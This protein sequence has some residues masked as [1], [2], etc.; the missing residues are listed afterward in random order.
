MSEYALITHEQLGALCARVKA[1]EE[2]NAAKPEFAELFFDENDIHPN[3]G[4]GS[5]PDAQ[6]ASFAS[7]TTQGGWSVA[8][9]VAS[10]TGT[11]GVV[12]GN[13]S[14]RALDTGPSNYW[15]KPI[16][17]VTETVSG[18]EFYLEE[19]AMQTTGAYDGSVYFDGSF[20]HLNPP[21]NPSY[22]VEYYNIENR[23][24]TL[25]PQADSS[26]V[27]EADCIIQNT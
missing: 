10:Y 22:V 9:N 23:T 15:A 6:P 14:L 18:R 12:R 4:G 17:R 11:A 27:F 1:L 20:V 8:G 5:A 26:I 25:T 24:A 16:V 21:A 13:I 19:L 3:D 2:S 7:N